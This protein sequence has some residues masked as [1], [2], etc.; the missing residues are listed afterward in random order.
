MAAGSLYIIPTVEGNQQTLSKKKFYTAKKS[1]VGLFFI[2][3]V[4]NLIKTSTYNIV[5]S[6][7]V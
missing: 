4:E 5:T 6:V 1:T 3:K 7:A 2:G